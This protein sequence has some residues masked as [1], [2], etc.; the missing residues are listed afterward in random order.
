MSKE[1]VKKPFYKKVWVWIVAIIIVFA[2]ASGGNAD[3]ETTSDSEETGLESKEEAEETKDDKDE[4]SGEVTT[5]KMGEATTIGDVTFT[6][7]DV[8]ETNEI[9]SGNEFIEN[10]TTDGKFAV[11]DVTV[12]NDKNESITI[13]SSYFKIITG[14]GVEYDPNTDREVMMAMGEELDDFF[15][16]QINPGL[17]KTGKV[18]FEVGGDVD[19]TN[20]VLKAQTG[21]WGTESIEIALGE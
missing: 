4:A 17:S 16:E 18:V 10:A 13:D 14:D 12:Q 21:F 7:N 3:T 20:A 19:L 11:L 15:L 6:V 2:I 5:A 1:K 9:D 8:E